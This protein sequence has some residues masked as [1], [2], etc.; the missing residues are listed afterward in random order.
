LRL[1]DVITTYAGAAIAGQPELAAAIGARAKDTG[2]LELTYVRSGAAKPATVQVPPGKLGV[3]VLG[4][5]QGKPLQL[6]P[7]ATDVAF[8]LDAYRAAPRDEWY[9]HRTGD[10][11][12]GF[13]HDRVEVKGDRLVITSEL[14]YDG[15]EGL[16]HYVVTIT[17]TAEPKP[18]LI[19]ARYE[20][21]LEPGFLCTLTPGTDGKIAVVLNDKG[22][23]TKGTIAPPSDAMYDTLALQLAAAMPMRAGTCLHYWMLTLTGNT[24]DPVGAC[25]GAP[26]AVDVGG[27]QVQAVPVTW[28][29]LGRQAHTLWVDAATRT[30]PKIE[31]TKTI[32]SVRTTREQAVAGVNP[33]LKPRT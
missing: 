29:T 13:Q 17:A 6:R 11:H 27:K 15:A 31:W 2:K 32:A 18:R 28:H 22:K 1:G 26:A 25:V 9:A 16:R 19:E 5:T 21:P 14:A 20:A 7:P 4:V 8:E 10:A 3:S 33:K 24:A 23:V 12:T 30:V